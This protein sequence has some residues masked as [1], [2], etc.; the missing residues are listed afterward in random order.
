[1]AKKGI[2]IKDLARDLGV[3]PRELLDRCRSEGVAAQNGITKLPVETERR[4]REWFNKAA[5]QPS[6]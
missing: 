6:E 4:V 5:D 1:V 2:K 3:T